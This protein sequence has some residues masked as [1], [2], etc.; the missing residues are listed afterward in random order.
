M[1]SAASRRTGTDEMVFGNSPHTLRTN[2]NYTCYPH[3]GRTGLPIIEMSNMG[4]RTMKEAV[5]T[6]FHETY[7]HYRMKNFGD[8]GTED[9]AEEF[10]QMMWRKISGSG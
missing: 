6:F 10:G 9:E 8:T 3:V 1:S 4:L 7:H 2:G 5:V